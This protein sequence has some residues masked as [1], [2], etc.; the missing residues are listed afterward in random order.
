MSSH[1]A[2]PARTDG[3]V[4][5]DAERGD[6]RTRLLVSVT[7]LPGGTPLEFVKAFRVQPLAEA[8]AAGGVVQARSEEMRGV[9]GAVRDGND[10]RARIDPRQTGAQ[11]PGS[12][13]C[14]IG[15]GNQK[16]IRHRCL[17]ERLGTGIKFAL[18]VHGVHQR[19]DGIHPIERCELAVR[20]ER[21]QIGTGS[22]SPV[23]SM[24]TLRNGGNVPARRFR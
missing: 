23:V 17:L 14:Q 24:R 16:A 6:V 7:P 1:S 2:R 12:G 8:R 13:R 4:V 3:L 5:V 19:D 18:S 21:L 15:L 11:A 20:E 10:L 22:A 9:D